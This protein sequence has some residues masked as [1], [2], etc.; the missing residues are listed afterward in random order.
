MQTGPE[1]KKKTAIKCL[2]TQRFVSTKEN[3]HG[4]YVWKNVAD[5]VS[6]LQRHYLQYWLPQ[7]QAVHG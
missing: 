7:K 6:R 2:E 1:K 5:I 3:L 4:T